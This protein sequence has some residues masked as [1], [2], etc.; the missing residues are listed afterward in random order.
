MNN[1]ILNKNLNKFKFKIIKILTLIFKIINNKFMIKK[2]K[3]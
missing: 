3:N 1:K 2:Y